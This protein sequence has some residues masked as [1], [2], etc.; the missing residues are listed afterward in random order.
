MTKTAHTK[1]ATCTRCH[2]TLTSAKSVAA[3]IGRTCAR[4]NR[5]EAAASVFTRTFKN[6]DAARAKALQLLTDNALVPTRHA[7]QYLATSSD[8]T[9]AYLVDTIERSC[10]C[11]GHQRVGR[12]YH[13]VAA[14]VAE[15]T[16]ARRTTYALAA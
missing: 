11:K 5:Q 14:D 1:T 2:A 8:G 4:L 16:T 7:G 3:R 12:C 13:L 15:V 9:A 10:T 6:A